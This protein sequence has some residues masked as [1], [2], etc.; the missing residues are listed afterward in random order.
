M[1][2]LQ[3]TGVLAISA[4]FML[5]HDV[6]RWAWAAGSASLLAAGTLFVLLVARTVC[7][8]SSTERFERWII[9]GALW[10][11]IA[12][13]ISLV[14]ATA[15]DVTIVQVVWP[16]AL[17]GFAGSWILGIGRRIFPGFLRWQPR[18]P[19]AEWPAFVIY[20]TSVALATAAAWP[21]ERGASE[22]LVIAS[23]GG[24]LVAVPLFSWCLGVRFR[25]KDRHDREGGYQRYIT[26][27]WFWL[28][29]ALVV[30]PLWTLVT[31]IQGSAPAPLVSDFARHAFAFGFV[32]QIMMGVATRILP[33]FTGN[34]LWS[35]R[36]RAAAFYLLNVSVVLRG[37]ELVVAAGMAAGAWPFI[38]AAGPPAVA[39][40]L[41]FGLNVVFTIFRHPSSSI[42]TASRI[43]S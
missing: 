39:A 40:V 28:F 41:L 32:A 36:A 35:P 37:L 33:V 4:A 15:G 11:A 17:W 19:A 18:C 8:F 25:E 13:G 2:G 20:Q 34:A 7:G 14:A 24:F 31:T 12:A 1:L 27:A 3:I 38:A 30:G 21:F 23:S 26:T 9:A 10:L 29:V 43:A 16:A 6:I 5:N 22:P 42:A